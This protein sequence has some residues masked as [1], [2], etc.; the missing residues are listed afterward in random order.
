[1]VLFS[2]DLINLAVDVE[3]MNAVLLPVVLGFLLLLEA[4]TLPDQYRMHGI[5]RVL[6]TTLCSIVM[7]LGLYTAAP[8]IRSAIF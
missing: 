7:V 2:V 6:V 5:Y 4:R 3:I 8:V 1:M